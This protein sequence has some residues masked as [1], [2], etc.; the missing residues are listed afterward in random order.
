MTVF[1]VLVI[2]ISTFCTILLNSMIAKIGKV[3]SAQKELEFQMT[4]ESEGLEA[5]KDS[6][7]V[8][9]VKYNESIGRFPCILV[10]GIFG[11]KAI[12]VEQEE[13]L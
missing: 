6:Y 3:E 8:A 2:V 9:V 7:N 4:T 12:H 11:F 5:A 1:F 10:A 13:S